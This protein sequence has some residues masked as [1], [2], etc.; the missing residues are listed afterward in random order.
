M[1]A[2]RQAIQAAELAEKQYKEQQSGEPLNTN[3]PEPDVAPVQDNPQVS[4][5]VSVLE[6]AEYKGLEDR[7]KKFRSSNEQT[8]FELRTKVNELSEKL[9][10]QPGDEAKISELHNRIESLEAQLVEASEN[11]KQLS[12]Y[13]SLTPEMREEL[14][15]EFINELDKSIENKINK[16]KNEQAEKDRK[17]QEELKEQ[18]KERE[19]EEEARRKEEELRA[20]KNFFSELDLLV[21]SWEEMQK[22]PSF[23]KFMAEK[24]EG[25]NET[26]LDMLGIAYGNLDVNNAA[27]W[28]KQFAAANGLSIQLSGSAPT[29]ESH[30]A[31]EEV[32]AG[33]DDNQPQGRHYT[34]SEWSKASFE[35]AEK[36]RKGRMSKDRYNELDSELKLAF[37]Q[38]RVRDDK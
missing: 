28:Y 25:T 21:P 38:G 30:Q 34:T 15:P 13:D 26:K 20:E 23:E 10:A 7:F 27:Y 33:G 24:A 31:P 14:D 6:S 5:P 36:L 35:I 19:E 18:Q 8:V 3:L 37:Q 12:M 1:T 17:R 11:A 9:N 29:L 2:P 16:F 32:G 4:K 22:H